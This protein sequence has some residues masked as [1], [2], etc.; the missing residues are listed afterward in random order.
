M[1]KPHKRLDAWKEAISLALIVYDLAKE[2]PKS[3]A[4]GMTGQIKRAAISI[5]ANIAEGAARQTKR[6]FAQFLYVAR[7]SM[8]EVDTYIE[9]A[10]NLG[11]IGPD[12]AIEID[13]KMM[14]IDKMLTGL[15]RSLKNRL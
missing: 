5:P 14:R 12:S 2:F 4:F 1:D 7:G 13:K 9:I 8:S 6:E 11:Y 15:I 10:K 3:E